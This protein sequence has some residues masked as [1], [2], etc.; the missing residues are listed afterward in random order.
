[1]GILILTT[2][3]EVINTIL[4]VVH[5]ALK[6]YAHIRRSMHVAQYLA[7]VVIEFGTLM[8]IHDEMTHYMITSGILTHEA[9]PL[10]FAE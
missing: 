1:M 9:I 3:R 10:L 5:D 4:R 6:S 8:F 7:I 2:I